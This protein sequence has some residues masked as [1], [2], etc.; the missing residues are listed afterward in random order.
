MDIIE[1]LES[2]ILQ[3]ADYERK[4]RLELLDKR[5]I[6]IED[7]VFRA[8][9]ILKNCRLIGS[10]ESIEHIMTIRMGIALKLIDFPISR[11]TALLM[12]TQKSHIQQLLKNR[13]LGIG[14]KMIDYIRAEIIR[15]TLA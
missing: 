7:S 10:R 4:A 12:L 5:R 2:I 3:F 1:K 13:K 15:E 11:I 14:T 8:Y 9:G 6:D